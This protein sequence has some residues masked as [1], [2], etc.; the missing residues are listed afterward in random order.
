MFIASVFGSSLYQMDV[1]NAF[2]NGLINKYT[3][4]NQED[5][6]FMGEIPM[7]KITKAL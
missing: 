4:M 5:L 6:R 3:L 1:H 7:C 2:L